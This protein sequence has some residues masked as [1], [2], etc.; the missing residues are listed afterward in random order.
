MAYSLL[1]F[2]SAS[3]GSLR[4]KGVGAAGMETVRRLAT[5]KDLLT[6]VI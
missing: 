2:Q 3:K 5:Y 1:T 4:Q 6:L